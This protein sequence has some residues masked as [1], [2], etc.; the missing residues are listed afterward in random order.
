MKKTTLFRK[1]SALALCS[2]LVACPLYVCAEETPAESMSYLDDDRITVESQPNPDDPSL[3]TGNSSENKTPTVIEEPTE[4]VPEGVGAITGIDYNTHPEI[5]DALIILGK[6]HTDSEYA[7]VKYFGIFEYGD[8]AYEG[9]VFWNT[10][11][12]AYSVGD[13]VTFSDWGIIETLPGELSEYANYIEGIVKG[14]TEKVSTCEEIGTSAK[15]LADSCM[16]YY[17]TDPYVWGDIKQYCYEDFVLNEE[18]FDY[19]RHCDLSYSEYQRLVADEE[20]FNYVSENDLDRD[21]YRQLITGGG[22]DSTLPKASDIVLGDVDGDGETSVLDVIS[23]NRYILGKADFSA[24]QIK[25]ADVDKSGIVDSADALL[26]M[27]KVVGIVE[28]F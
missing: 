28:E 17:E 2:A 22:L 9:V 19:V 26:M 7:P 11:N 18:V 6:S 3:S 4:P 8:F 12:D 10:T 5:N 27:K 25:S 13:I 20:L 1:V 21:E 24:S 23:V 14:T 15:Q 16:E